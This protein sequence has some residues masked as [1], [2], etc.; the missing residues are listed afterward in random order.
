MDWTRELIT[1]RKRLAEL[2]PTKSDAELVLDTI[3][4]DKAV[5]AFNDKAINTWNSILNE[6]HN[7]GVL[8]KLVETISFEFDND[9]VVK[10]ALNALKAPTQTVV[11]PPVSTPSPP[12]TRAVSEGLQ[13][14]RPA[15]P[16]SAPQSGFEFFNA[17]MIAVIT[18][19]G[20]EAAL[21]LVREYVKPLSN[22]LN[23]SL[24]GLSA[25]NT[26]NNKERSDGIIEMSDFRLE[27][28]R[29]RAALLSFMESIPREVEISDM[30]KGVSF[31][32]PHDK[33]MER[34]LGTSENLVQ[35]SWL[36][37]GI[38]A[39]KSVCRVVCADGSKGTGFVVDGGYLITNNHVLP[40]A[41]AAGKAQ[42]EFNYEED[43]FGNRQRTTT[44]KLDSSDFKT[45]HK[46]LLDYS[47]VKIIDDQN[48]PISDWGTLE[49]DTFSDPQI[50]A[51]VNIIQH[52]EGGTKQIAF[53]FNDILSV[54]NEKL[55]YRTDTKKGSS[56]SPVFNMEWKVIALH[57]AGKT[58]DDGGM[59]INEKGDIAAANLGILMKFIDADIRR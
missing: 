7:R 35:V 25:R 27:R 39:A 21:P 36:S 58:M 51:P 5:I 24:V 18:E 47:R 13:V 2:Y 19:D 16:M 41:A 10:D 46:S 29:I 53:T 33:D 34:I 45:S 17:K 37:K 50:G 15:T 31:T 52:P 14:S 26:R 22:S 57:R 20:I 59:Q 23:N 8:F 48:S 43:M 1:L 9:P 3:N 40:D 44:Y 28:N 32:I 12:P 49:M 30:V 4:L 56:G 38:Q 42:I 54:W 11:A 55:F 6:A